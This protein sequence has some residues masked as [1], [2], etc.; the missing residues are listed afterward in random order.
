MAKHSVCT[1]IISDLHLCE[2]EPVH[3]KFPLWKKY[4]TAE[5]FFDGVFKNFIA[6]LNERA[7]GQK[8]ELV[9]NGDIFDFDSVTSLPKSP[10]F[11]INW[12]EKKRG[13]EA[14]PERSMF[15]IQKIMEDH[16]VFMSQ[17]KSFLSEGHSLVFIIGN[18]D[19][20]LHFPEVQQAIR[21]NLGVQSD[22]DSAVR[23][24]EWFYISESDTLIE[25]GNQY[26]PYCVCEDPVHPFVQAY[27]FKAIK[28]PFGNLACR[29]IL[30]GM[31]FFNPHV[32]S[33]FI[34]SLK[35]YVRFFAKY[36]L[37]AQPL[38]MI[39]WLFGACLTLWYSLTDRFQVA[40]RDPLKIEERI[41]RIAE[42]AKAQPRM[43]RELRELFSESASNNPIKI[44]QEL[45]LDRAFIVV[46]AF[47]F[48]FQV[49]LVVKQFFN[50]SFFW[51]LFP[52][53]LFLPFFILYSRSVS[54]LVSSYKEPDEQ[55][56]TLAGR[57][58]KVQRIVYGHTHRPRH[59]IIGSIEHLN[60]GCWSA[61]FTDV[62]CT[63]PVDQK[64]FV[65]IEPTEN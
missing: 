6:H 4:K 7:K 34:M 45:W 36:M 53:S 54:S 60:S 52:L 64:T 21:N 59:E 41:E 30:N 14:R 28:L 65:W 39:D 2:A 42:K 19:V 15:K 25:H 23:F 55:V 13:L 49:M 26:D 51:M 5:F 40:I 8:I 63:I 31:G 58:T 47:L 62:E 43:V 32:D 1:A 20:E 9:L 50:V 12:I 38:L 11:H 24:C 35:D 3:P 33:N 18:H 56:L 17:L 16:V 10:S 57:I 44:M 46:L 48:I 29:Y 27:N 22:S 61:A 37:R